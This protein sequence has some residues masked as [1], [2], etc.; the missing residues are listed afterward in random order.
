M[1]VATELALKNKIGVLLVLTYE[2]SLICGSLYSRG[3][4][5]VVE[6][7]AWLLQMVGNMCYSWLEKN[8]LR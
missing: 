8:R 3:L 6:M 1:F 2:A 5:A 4:A 7:R